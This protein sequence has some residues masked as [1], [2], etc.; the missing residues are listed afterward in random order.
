MIEGTYYPTLLPRD[1]ESDWIP[2]EERDTDQ[3]YLT[4]QFHEEIGEWSDLGLSFGELPKQVIKEQDEL[5][6]L[7]ELLL[8]IYQTSGSC[9]GAGGL[10]AMMDSI[11]GDIIARGDFEDVT[12]PFHLPTY[13]VG[14]AIGGMR[15]RGEG[16]YGGAQKRAMNEFGFVYHEDIPTLPKPTVKDGWM[17]YPKA[18]EVAWSHSSYFP[19]GHSQESLSQFAKRQTL[20]EWKRCRSADDV[21]AAR[22]ARWGVTVACNFGTRGCR[23][24]DERLIAEWDASWC[25]NNL[26]GAM[27][28]TRHRAICSKSTT[29]GATRTAAVRC[30]G[31]DIRATALIGCE[32]Q[33][34]IECAQQ[35]RCTH[36]ATPLGVRL[37][38]ST[39][40]ISALL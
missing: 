7:G 15:G 1:I 18:T 33:R 11:I 2:Y 12:I 5:D 4:D 29:N 26:S 28:N 38:S 23:V 8:R 13:G 39:G 34:W 9:V 40:R 21:K 27:T 10:T 25:I 14:R 37:T 17:W 16:S 3:K 36:S 32:G 30:C 6:V 19:D 35:V 22:A 31:A 20:R 24:I